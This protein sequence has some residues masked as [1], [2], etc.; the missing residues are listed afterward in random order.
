MVKA[1]KIWIN[2]T[3]G[4]VE[5]DRSCTFFIFM[6]KLDIENPF[7]KEIKVI[8]INILIRKRQKFLN[9]DC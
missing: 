5:V 7:Y 9:I 1:L 3:K 6:N 4:H 2:C 8:N